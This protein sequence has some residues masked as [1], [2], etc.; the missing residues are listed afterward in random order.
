M[1]TDISTIYDFLVTRMTALF[2][3]HKRLSN[4]YNLSLNND[5]FLEQGWGI[6]VGPGENTNRQLGNRS[7]TKREF[8][9]VLTR[10]T[11]ATELGTTAKATGDK[12]LLEDLQILI[13]RFESEVDLDSTSG[14]YIA[15]YIG[16]SGITQVRD[17]QDG[18]AAIRVSTS[19]E[20]FKTLT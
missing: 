7:S 13:D 5:Q 15:R 8:T 6:A 20:Y 4:P 14:K 16:D 17:D 2:P 12:D 19:V 11:F 9:L 18:F 1:S 10:R 3:N